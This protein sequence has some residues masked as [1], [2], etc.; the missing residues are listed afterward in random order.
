VKRSKYYVIGVVLILALL[1]ITF[2]SHAVSA[3]SVPATPSP[4]GPFS[5]TI[6]VSGQGQADVQP[7]QA[8]VQL[9]VQ[10]DADTANAALTANST[11]MRGLLSAVQQAGVDPADVQTQQVTLSPR[12]STPG[13]A[14]GTPQLVGYTASNVVQVRV[15]DLSKLGQLLDSA[16]R[17]GSNRL[18]GIQFVVSNP[19]KVE[20]QARQ[21]AWNNALAKAQQLAGLAGTG[22][23]DVLT[24]DDSSGPS[25]RPFMAASVAGPPGAPVPVQPGTQTVESTLQVTWALGGT[26]TMAGP[27]PPTP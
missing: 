26:T 22:L 12:Y 16:V 5:R 13:E 21:A 17:A 3:Q 1:P 8:L 7:D 14:G 20:A 11:Q 27:T 19:A 4:G 23:G 25:P 15:R 24:I 18:Q 2:G 6:T 9:G 10:N